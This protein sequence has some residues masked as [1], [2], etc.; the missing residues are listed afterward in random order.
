M[1]SDGDCIKNQNNPSGKATKYVR[2]M[3]DQTVDGTLL[4]AIVYHFGT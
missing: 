3:G 2:N 4:T 1:S